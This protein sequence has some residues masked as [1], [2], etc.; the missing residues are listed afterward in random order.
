MSRV[1]EVPATSEGARKRKRERAGGREMGQVFGTDGA[2]MRNE[3]VDGAEDEGDRRSRRAKEKH[4]PLGGRWEDGM[5]ATGLEDQEQERRKREKRGMGWEVPLMWRGEMGKGKGGWAKDRGGRLEVQEQ[6]TGQGTGARGAGA[7]AEAEAARAAPRVTNS[8]RSNWQAASS[9]QPGSEQR[10]HSGSSGGGDLLLSGRKECPGGS[11]RR[12]GQC[13]SER[14]IPIAVCNRHRH[15]LKLRLPVPMQQPSSC[16]GVAV[17]LLAGSSQQAGSKARG[18]WG[19]SPGILDASAVATPHPH[20]PSSG[21]GSA[22]GL[23]NLEITVGQRH[24]T[25]RQ[26]RTRHWTGLDRIGQAGTGQWGVVP[27]EVSRLVSPGQYPVSKVHHALF[28]FQFHSDPA[29]EARSPPGA[30]V[31]VRRP[32]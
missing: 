24:A 25:P 3:Q 13:A 29:Q 32:D 19:P 4:E 2:G 27:R 22:T 12:G 18:F 11:R 8:G 16:P 26:V 17:D 5:V 30:G 14:R 20:R 28:R 15:H 10:S 6:P 31:L 1:G 21:R 23:C 9:N 7:G